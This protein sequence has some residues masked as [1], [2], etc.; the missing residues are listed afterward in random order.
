MLWLNFL[1]FYQ[2]A[3]AET[4]SIKK[5]MSKSYWRLLR[6][7]DEHPDLHLTWNVSGCLLER[8]ETEKEQAWLDRLKFLVKRGRIE[9]IGS[10][11]YHGFLPLLPEEEVIR[12]IRINEKILRKHF[13][14]DFKPSGFFLPE[15]AYSP[16]VARLVKKLG[17]SWL[18][19]D[20]I[21]YSGDLRRRPDFKLVYQDEASG[22]K[23]IFRDRALSSSY[24]PDKLLPL[25]KEMAA[26]K[27]TADSPYIT[28]T[29]AEL[30][31]LRHED[32]TAELEKIVKIKG[33]KTATIS[34][35]LK[36][37]RKKPEKIKLYSCSWETGP[38]DIKAG[39][40]YRLWRNPKN[41]IHSDLWRLAELALSLG[42][43]FKDDKNY[44]WY[45]WHLVR[46]LASC[47]FWWA[48]AHDFS[49]IFGPYAWSPDDVERG[50]E[51]LVRS[52]RSLESG[53]SKKYKLEAE[54]YYLRIKKML[55]QEHWRKHWQ[56]TI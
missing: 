43:K 52:V 46:G 18:I 4:Y 37:Q 17:Y 34:S 10:A 8:L 56:K 30:Y 9:L 31:G 16:A 13:G 14:R 54:K 22:L 32:P 19:L 36:S 49:K 21:A 25:F 45:R 26:R 42:G 38:A 20:E 24:P 50:L 29:D 44:R 39:Q 48:S 7:A 5:A 55:W 28:A 23:I 15:M 51:D 1:H 27:Q 35:W 40:P 47:T 41:K 33:L 11:A 2:P 53:R 3:N 12:Q 6:L